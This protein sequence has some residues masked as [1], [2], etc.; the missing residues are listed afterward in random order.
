MTKQ[1][2]VVIITGMSGSGKSTALR[3]LEDIGFFCVDN[4]PVVLL[5][6]FLEIQSDAAKEISRV[7]MVMDLR[8]MEFLEK[9]QRIF[10]RLKEKGYRI[11]VLFFDA[12]DEAILHRFSETRRSHPLAP[13]GSLI[14]GISLERKKLAALKGMADQVIDTTSCNV[15][16][17][18]DIVQRYF[19]GAESGKRLVVHVTSFGYRYGLPADADIVLDVRFLANPYFVELLRPL[20]GHD[21]RVR[22][23][24]LESNDGRIFIGKLV[25]LMTFLIP[26]YEKEGKSRIHIA[27]GCTGGHHRSVVMANYLGAY[28]ADRSYFVNIAHRDIGKS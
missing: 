5:P 9:Y 14:E 10:T 18:K 7:A 26:L 3:A 21:P 11:E 19:L 2:R 28:F 12:T 22:D 8:E 1:L 4:L 23:Y 20:D 27:L 24:V 15:H 13:R 6:K 17:L 25:D 16:Q